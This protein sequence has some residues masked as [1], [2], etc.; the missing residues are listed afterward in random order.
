M[1]KKIKD[2]I[3]SDLREYMSKLGMD[4][5]TRDMARTHVIGFEDCVSMSEDC[6]ADEMKEIATALR[7]A[8]E[9]KYA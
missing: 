7:E 4:F 2:K 3:I 5:I 8:F 1:S 6:N 9:K